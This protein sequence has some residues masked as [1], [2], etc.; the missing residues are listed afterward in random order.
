[1]INI[2]YDKI[3][4]KICQETGKS[5]DEITKLVET[6][7]KQL[8]GLISR[9]GAAYIVANE[10]GVS[11]SKKT[12]FK[13]N[14]I[15]ETG[16]ITTYGRVIRLFP[17]SEFENQ[18][19]KGKVA[20]MYLG[21]ETGTVRVTAWHNRVEELEKLKEND[22]IK[23]EDVTIKINNGKKELHL[24]SKSI[25]NINPEGVLISKPS[26]EIVRKTIKELKDNERN[27]ELAGTIVQIFDPYF[28]EKNNKGKTE[29]GVVLN[30]ILD[31][32]LGTI[33]TVFFK[34]QIMSLLNL[35][36]NQLFSYKEHSFEEHKTRL[37]GEIIK[38]IGNIK[39]NTLFDRL[40]FVVNNVNTNVNPEEEIK[41]LQKKITETETVN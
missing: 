40:E 30:L 10:L 38:I 7:L 29:Q 13:I 19:G 16:F 14:E 27:V 36:E 15:P 35:S 26:T 24:N 31:D 5:Q 17:V 2:P 33:R 8:P 25:L 6:K 1:M 32:G 4:E 28:F 11:I 21:D 41:F 22:I 18:Y 3:L 9:E 34:E 23:L 39:K 12:P 37:L 20:S